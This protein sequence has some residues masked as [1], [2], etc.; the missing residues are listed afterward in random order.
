LR[1]FAER[2]ALVTNGGRGVGRAV[3][4]QLA[5]EGAY[6]I[7]NYTQGDEEGKYIVNELRDIGTLAHAVGGN[8]SRSIDVRRVFALVDETYG[9]LDILVNSAGASDLHVPFAEL[10]EEIWDEALNLSLKATFLCSQ[11]AAHLMSKR[12]SP[13]IVNVASETG[14]TGQGSGAHTVAAHAGIVGLTKA[15][16]HQLAPRIRVN[17]VAQSAISQ[18][19]LDD[20]ARSC[21]YLLSSDAA[22]I[23]GQTLVVS[24]SHLKG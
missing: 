18:V 2:V 11:A 19:A 6:V 13:A 22:S 17:C 9:R 14:L 3:A 21:I 24:G 12:P 5:L 23:T 16:A 8:M 10:T 7:V 1:G 20:M 15:L 4:L